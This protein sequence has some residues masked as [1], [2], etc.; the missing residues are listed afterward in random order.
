MDDA[1]ADVLFSNW[2]K[3]AGPAR[4]G[5][6]LGIRSEEGKAAPHARIDADLV[7]VA[8]YAAV[9]SFRALRPGVE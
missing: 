8:K 2:L 4:P 9:S 6:K 7:V 5:V 3:E 1:G